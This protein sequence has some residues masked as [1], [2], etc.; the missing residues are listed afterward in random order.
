MHERRLTLNKRGKG[1]GGSRSRFN[2]FFIFPINERYRKTMNVKFLKPAAVI[3]L[4]IALFVLTSGCTGS[5]MSSHVSY[6]NG[7]LSV[8]NESVFTGCLPGH[9]NCTFSCVD[10]QSDDFNCGSCGTICTG[11]GLSCRKGTC[12]CDPGFTKCDDACADLKNDNFNCGSCG[13]FCAADEACGGGV[14]TERSTSPGE[15]R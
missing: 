10:L 6:Q 5:T 9:T 14:C 15:M 11:I 13:N 4:V 12:A 7:N 3:V 8:T 2:T 1:E